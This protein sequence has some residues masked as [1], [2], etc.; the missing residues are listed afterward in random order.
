MMKL[1]CN[2]LCWMNTDFPQMKGQVSVKQCLSEI[3][4]I[5][6]EG[7]EME[8]PFLKVIKDLPVWLHERKLQ[9]IGK[10]HSTQLLENSLELEL[11]KLDKHCDMLEALGA[12]IVNLAECSRAVHQNKK[13]SLST[14]PQIQSDEEWSALCAGMDQLA[15]SIEERGMISAYHHHMGT[16]V[17]SSEDI[18]RLMQ[19]TQHL[20]LL[21]DTGHLL[22][23]EAEPMTVLQKHISRVT[24]VHCKSVRPEILREKIEKKSSFFEA[25]MDGIFTVPGDEGDIVD[26]QRMADLL[27]G[28]N[29]QGWLVVEAEQDPAKADPFTYAQLGYE[30]LH[31]IAY[32]AEYSLDG[33]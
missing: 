25:V 12:K 30:T 9:C 20:G 32:R 29:Y 28:S 2:P 27:S 3:A 11:E 10:W 1:G 4:M 21:F 5:G 7:V 24:H 8:D 18:D 17:Q 19:G 22:F 16:V 31:S 15:K 26:Y 33:I 14:R 6:F 13:A 23:A